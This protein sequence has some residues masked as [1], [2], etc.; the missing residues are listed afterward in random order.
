MILNFSDIDP[1][2]GSSRIDLTSLISTTNK[3][4]ISDPVF[5]EILDAARS[6]TQQPFINI[7]WPTD[8]TGKIGVLRESHRRTAE[9]EN[10]APHQ[11]FDIYQMF[12]KHGASSNGALTGTMIA[13]AESGFC[14][15][16]T[17]GGDTPAL[18]LF[19]GKPNHGWKAATTGFTL[20]SQVPMIKVM[21]DKYDLASDSPR[22]LLDVYAAH[23]VPGIFKKV[24]PQAEGFAVLGKNTFHNQYVMK[25]S[26]D[27]LYTSFAIAALW[28]VTSVSKYLAEF[29]LDVEIRL[30]ANPQVALL[31]MANKDY[32]FIKRVEV[33]IERHSEILQSNYPQTGFPYGPWADIPVVR[34][35]PKD[36]ADTKKA[37]AAGKSAPSVKPGSV[38]A[39]EASP[40]QQNSPVKTTKVRSGLTISQ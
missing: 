18:G 14:S 40:N 16:A 5:R 17:T 28:Q 21:I 19:Q 26:N 20:D 6:G 32:S 25:L 1:T 34:V 38:N 31:N 24:L 30:P 36:V 9:R 37:V 29:K 39:I 10:K 13:A 11:P 7:S 12:I 27:L 8:G 33:D 35:T 4:K 15:N 22:S 3:V 23:F 2:S